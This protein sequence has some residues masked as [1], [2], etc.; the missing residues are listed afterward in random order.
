MK[1]LDGVG[2]DYEEFK[3]CLEKEKEVELVGINVQKYVV[4]LQVQ[5]L[6]EVMKYVNIDIVGGEMQFVNSILNFVNRGK[7]LDGLINNLIYFSQLSS[8]LLNGNGGG[9]IMQLL[10]LI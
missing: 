2:K 1:K 3:L 9:M 10:G 8:G 4:E 7:L 6:G 5:V